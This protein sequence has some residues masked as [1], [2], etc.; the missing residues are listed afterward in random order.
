MDESEK[1]CLVKLYYEN[2]RSVTCAI[3][4][5]CS[6]KGIKTKSAVPKEQTVRDLI[7]R[8]EETGSVQ[9]RRTGSGRPPVSEEE[10]ALVENLLEDS[11]VRN[12]VLTLHQK[13]NM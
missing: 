3:R 7:N 10:I 8:F 2:Q 4:K 1:I 5:F 6:L 11:R 12:I 9:H 13:I